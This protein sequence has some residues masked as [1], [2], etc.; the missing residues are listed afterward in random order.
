MAK[1]G[2]ARKSGEAAASVTRAEFEALL[3][4]IEDLEDALAVNE[5]LANPSRKT[6]PL[7]IVKRLIFGEESKIVVWRAHRGL[8]ARALA[9]KA[10]VAPTY[11]SE[12]E[13]GKK[14]GS[15]KALAAIARAL[16]VEIEA[17]IDHGD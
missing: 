12:I 11:L 10:G 2:A 15:V 4:R 13:S 3:D 16:D 6:V 8:T 14:P 7:D 17:L 5:A 9:E 1:R